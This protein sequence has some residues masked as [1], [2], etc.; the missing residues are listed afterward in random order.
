MYICMRVC[1]YAC[2]YV[3]MYMC[4]Y[5]CMYMCMCV[6]YQLTLLRVFSAIHA[7]ASP[8]LRKLELTRAV[9]HRA[10]RQASTDTGCAA[11]WKVTHSS[12][13]LVGRTARGGPHLVVPPESSVTVVAN[14]FERAAGEVV[15]QSFVPVR[16]RGSLIGVL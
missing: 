4:M 5:V 8:Y 11:P 13:D 16:Q 9:Q 3:F 14:A 12:P 15:E 2:V 7:S 10:K 1:V 6:C